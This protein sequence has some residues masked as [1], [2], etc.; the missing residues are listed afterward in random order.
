MRDWS[1]K[2]NGYADVP[3]VVVSCL[4]SDQ[5]ATCKT[6]EMT[7]LWFLAEIN[8]EDPCKLATWLI[9][10]KKLLYHMYKMIENPHTIWYSLFS[11]TYV[12]GNLVVMNFKSQNNL[13]CCYAKISMLRQR[14]V[15]LHDSSKTSFS[16]HEVCKD[17]SI[18]HHYE[19]HMTTILNQ[20]MHQWTMKLIHLNVFSVVWQIKTKT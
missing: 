16:Q 11:S 17:H 20:C 13:S 10:K 1:N 8:H 6:F 9:L 15:Y 19:V 14:L 4:K 7:A 2:K 12:D 18:Y 3:Y 5:S